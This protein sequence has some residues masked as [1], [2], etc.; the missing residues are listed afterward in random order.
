MAR[1]ALVTGGGR[2]I[3]R[4]IAM[5]LARDGAKV[6]VSARSEDELAEVVATIQSA[7]GQAL[8]VVADLSQPDAA[9]A[10]LERVK[11][12]LGAIEILV[13][14]AGV[15]SSADPRPVIDFDDDFWELSLRV[16]LTVPYLLSKGVLPD[17]V[18]RHWGRIINIA[19][20]NSRTGSL[21]GAAYAASKHGLLGL[22]RTLA[23]EV[24]RD[25][26]TV[27][28]ICPGPVRTR[29]NDKRIAYDAERRGVSFKEQEASLTPIGG[30][31]EP[32][33]IAPMA[34]YL[35][36]DAARMVTGQAFNIC[37]GLLMS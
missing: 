31:L 22:T 30:R 5:A 32:D 12:Q 19:S 1:I 11:S 35:A 8:P 28:A 6:A 34:V 10:L 36:G 15:G 7:G 24:A 21:H 14:N 33:D 26:I 3:G 18:A 20:I 9:R 2:G 16:N 29:M 25:G 37:G 13:N 4:A 17:M 23:L 27:N